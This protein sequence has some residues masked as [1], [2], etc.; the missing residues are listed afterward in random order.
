MKKRVLSLFLAFTLSLSLLPSS[1]ALAEESLNENT[2]VT[3]EETLGGNT[4]TTQEETLGENPSTT[5]EETLG[6]NPS[7]TQQETQGET[8][9]STPPHRKMRW[10]KLRPPPLHSPRSIRKMDFQ[11]KSCN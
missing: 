8:M 1:V 3:Q 6:E 11:Y 9:P 4:P 5:Q 2:P 7:T 10:V